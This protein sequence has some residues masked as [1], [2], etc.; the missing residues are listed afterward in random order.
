MSEIKWR[1]GRD[2]E[3]ALTLAAT[4]LCACGGMGP[5]DPGVCV[6]CKMWHAVMR[7]LGLV[8]YGLGTER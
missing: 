4:D 6:A 1:S 2:V 8:S 5:D 7:A 3:R